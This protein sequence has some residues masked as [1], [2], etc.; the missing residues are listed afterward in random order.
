MT[1][2]AN[3]KGVTAWLRTTGLHSSLLSAVVLASAAVSPVQV[4]AQSDFE[5]I[6][7]TSLR[8]AV[9]DTLAIAN[10][11]ERIGLAIERMT[12]EQVSREVVA[13]VADSLGAVTTTADEARECQPGAEGIPLS[14][15]RLVGVSSL[16]WARI[17]ENQSGVAKVQV[18]WFAPAG[19]GLV[20]AGA[21]LQ[22]VRKFG[23]WEFV[24]VL[25]RFIR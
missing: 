5:A 12:V 24:R 9:S 18:S 16:L 20:L 2:Q 4:S 17:L 19:D 10:H 22:L 8:W 25:T 11:A 21:T 15:C 13:G 14:Q 6:L 23:E 7:R 3:S 1:N